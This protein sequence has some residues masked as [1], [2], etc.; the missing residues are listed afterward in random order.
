M[1]IWLHGITGRVGGE[2]VKAI[3]ARPEQFS[4]I[5]GA[6]KDF[7]Y[8]NVELNKPTP[9]SDAALVECLKQSDMIIDFS[10]PDGTRHLVHKLQEL[11]PKLD[12][13]PALLIGTTGIKAPELS[14]I[15]A[16]LLKQQIKILLTPN[17]SVGIGL[18]LQA[19]I[20]IAQTAIDAGFDMSLLDIHHRHKIDRPSGTALL[21]QDQ[22]TKSL[23]QEA[24]MEIVAQ[25]T[26]GVLGEHHLSFGSDEEMIHIS[27]VALSR[28]L[29]AKGALYL[30]QWLT[31]REP[32]LYTWEDVWGVSPHP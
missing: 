15:A 8:A 11:A 5:G 24:P 27:H 16:E 3:V 28:A 7:L 12:K 10:L 23:S 14:Q 29:F 22:I 2:L 13:L 25:R 26:G 21:I 4:L 30:S 20:R 9:W 18:L 32:G 17:T 1:K 6:N 31:Q 19:S